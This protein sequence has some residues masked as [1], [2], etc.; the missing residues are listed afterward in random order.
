MEYSVHY[1]IDFRQRQLLQCIKLLVLVG[2]DDTD[3]TETTITEEL[4]FKKLAEELEKWGNES[5]PR[6]WEAEGLGVL[7]H[8][9][10]T[11]PKYS[12]TREDVEYY[13]KKFLYLCNRV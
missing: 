5:E 2:L 13:Y 10:E 4:I 11:D 1:K 12:K 7:F 3:G 8:E 6:T 9:F